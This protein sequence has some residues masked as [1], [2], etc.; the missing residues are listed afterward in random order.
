MDN[1]SKEL[2]SSVLP[3]LVPTENQRHEHGIMRECWVLNHETGKNDAELAQIYDF[4]LMI[5]FGIRS[6]QT[7]NMN[8]HPIVWK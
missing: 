4:G 8:L 2:C 5:G 1:I 7:W 3:V 6:Q